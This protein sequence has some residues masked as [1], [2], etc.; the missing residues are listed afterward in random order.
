VL[1]SFL[2][3]SLMMNEANYGHAWGAGQY[4]A[5]PSGLRCAQCAGSFGCNEAAGLSVP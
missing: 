3:S 5:M 2:A 1:H 4:G